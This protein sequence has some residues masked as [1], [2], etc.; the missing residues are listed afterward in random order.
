MGT[1]TVKPV[2][3]KT[4]N[5]NGSSTNETSVFSTP[6]IIL[7]VVCCL[8]LLGYYPLYCGRKTKVAVAGLPIKDLEDGTTEYKIG[9]IA[10]KGDGIKDATDLETD[11]TTPDGPI[12]VSTDLET[13]ATTPEIV[14]IGITSG[15]GKT[16]KRTPRTPSLYE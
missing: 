11:A 15:E 13:D 9:E 4:E 6:F 10:L 7:S 16:A 5:N 1:T 14:G 3:F 8:L 12:K 2:N